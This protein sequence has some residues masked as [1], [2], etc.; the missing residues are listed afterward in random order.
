M[1]TKS[2]QWI[3]G[4]SIRASAQRA[5]ETRKEA[6]CLACEAWKWNMRMLGYKGPAQPSCLYREL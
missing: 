2:R 5:K 4:A 3:Y 1:T 6:N